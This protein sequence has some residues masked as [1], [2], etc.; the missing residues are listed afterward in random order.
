M[1]WIRSHGF[2]RL[3]VEGSSYH[4]GA[5]RHRNSDSSTH[6]DL[7]QFA[8]PSL[9]TIY[10]LPYLC[11]CFGL[12]KFF[13]VCILPPVTILRQCFIAT[14]LLICVFWSI[15]LTCFR[16][17][18]SPFPLLGFSLESICSRTFLFISAVEDLLLPHI[19]TWRECVCAHIYNIYFDSHFPFVFRSFGR[20]FW[21]LWKGNLC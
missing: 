13:C 7:R 2:A 12:Q 3:M 4:F 20:S 19:M 9:V 11:V 14:F 8:K 10:F 5:I 16:H 15:A 6:V 17:L 18:C 21:H 1:E